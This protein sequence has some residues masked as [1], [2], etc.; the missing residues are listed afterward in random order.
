M[1][2]LLNFVVIWLSISIFVVATSWYIAKTIAPLYP[3]WWKRVVVDFEPD[4]SITQK[5]S[6]H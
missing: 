4:F 1:H 2:W 6:R 5:Q 3:N